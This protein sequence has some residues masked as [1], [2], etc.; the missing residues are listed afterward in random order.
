MQ[1]FRKVLLDQETFL[2]FAVYFSEKNAYKLGKKVQHATTN[3][4]FIKNNY[5]NIFIIR[6]LHTKIRGFSLQSETGI[7]SL[8]S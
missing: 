2:F 7:F 1:H 8:H 6:G 3:N 5:R 4:F